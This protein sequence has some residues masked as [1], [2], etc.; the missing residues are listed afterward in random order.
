[1][2]RLRSFPKGRPPAEGRAVKRAWLLLALAACPS[3]PPAPTARPAPAADALCADHGVL[4]TLCAQ[5]NPALAAVFRARGDFCDEHGQALTL[6]PIH[7]PERGGRPAVAVVTDDGPAEGLKLRLKTREIAAQAGLQTFLLHQQDFTPAVEAPARLVWDGTKVAR[8][9]A[10]TAGVLRELKVE[11]GARVAQGDPL[12]IL[13]SAS[14]AAEAGVVRAS[15][16]RVALAGAELDRVR[17]F[18]TA[19]LSAENELRRAQQELEA[20]R[21]ELSARE[22]SLEL[23]GSGARSSGRVALVAPIAGVV[24]ER[25][26]SI[27]QVVAAGAPLFTIVDPSALWLELDLAERDA[28]AV[29]EGLPVSFSRADVEGPPLRTT[30]AWLSPELDPRTRTVRARA[31]LRNPDG[32]LRANALGRARVELGPPVPAWLVP[33]AAVQRQGA[34]EW[35]FLQRAPDLFEVRRVRSHPAGDGLR[36]VEGALADGDQV[37]TTGAFLLT[38]ETRKDRIGAGCCDVEG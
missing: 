16:G 19:G 14:V 13:E 35:L 32:T 26:A 2:R 12:A 20:A 10:R 23:A 33:T 6:C 17:R 7:H 22:A 29:R 15:R 27:G 25:L 4:A 38:T 28:G 30:L 18:G 36:R 37:V 5:H 8:P 9:E 31:A 24:T 11:V 34:H 21:G 3:S 1:M